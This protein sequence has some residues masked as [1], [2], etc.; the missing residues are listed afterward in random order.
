[1]KF[2]GV[3]QVRIGSPIDGEKYTAAE[4]NQQA[5]EWIEAQM[6]EISSIK[7]NT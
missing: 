3:I 4:I 2:P 5:E 7:S 1:M 6:A